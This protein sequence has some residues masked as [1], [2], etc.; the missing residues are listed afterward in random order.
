MFWEILASAFFG[1]FLATILVAWFTQKW[2]EGR[3]RRDRRD[4]LRLE[5]YLDVVDLILDN[6]LALA[7][8][9]SEGQFPPV[10]LQVKRYGISHRLKLLG[11]RDA[12]AAYQEYSRL[13]FQET[14]HPVERRPED[15]NEVFRARERLISVMAT[16]M[17]NCLPQ[18]SCLKDKGR[19]I[20]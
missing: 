19:P 3:E 2:I 17:G 8:R 7:K 15:P 4:R 1:S 14:A 9:G 5:L 10:D 16:D 6:E 12:Q 20:D 18:S 11:S 13:V